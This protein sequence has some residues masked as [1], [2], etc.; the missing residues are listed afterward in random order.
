MIRY[1]SGGL[2]PAVFDMAQKGVG[3]SFHLVTIYVD[4]DVGANDGEE[5]VGHPRNSRQRVGRA[6]PYLRIHAYPRK[7]ANPLVR[8]PQG[9][10]HPFLSRR[11]R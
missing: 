8:E 5:P 3:K 2:A 6:H 7:M 1:D 10:A 9:M 4:P 11:Y